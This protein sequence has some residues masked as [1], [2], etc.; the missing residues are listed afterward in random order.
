MRSDSL[1]SFAYVGVDDG[2]DEP[3]EIYIAYRPG[4]LDDTTPIP[5][6]GT[7]QLR[8]LQTGKW[9]R[10]ATL[11]ADV[12]VPKSCGD[13]GI[14]CDQ[15]SPSSATVLTYTGTGM[16]YNG[17]PLVPVPPSSTLVL[18]LGSSCAPPGSEQLTFPSATMREPPIAGACL[19]C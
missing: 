14:L 12:L 3:P 5:P 8:N 17:V 18:L 7:A 15:D 10:L 13:Q 11:T 1:T 16:S 4:A 9:C 2:K 19:Q 6:G